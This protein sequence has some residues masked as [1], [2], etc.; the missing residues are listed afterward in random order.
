[1]RRWIR[2]TLYSL[3]SASFLGLFFFEPRQIPAAAQQPTGSIPT[4][5]G[6][7]SGPFIYVTNPEQINVRS[8]PSSVYYDAIGVLLTGETAPALGK[9]PGGSWIEIA[10]PGVPSGVGWV[11]SP[12]VSLSPGFLPIV[13]PP[14]TATPRVTVTLDPTLAF[15]LLVRPTPTHLPTFTPP[16]ALQIPTF[17]PDT[18]TRSGV[19]MGFVI[20]G[21]A[22]IGIFG[23]VISFVSGGR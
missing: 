23:A 15:A 4:V 11:Y 9:S 10:Y 13:E 12:L 8:G 1:M 16:S 18:S 3:L 17:A 2:I 21:L 7:P 14:P 20:L 5:T 19:P 22:I 6:S